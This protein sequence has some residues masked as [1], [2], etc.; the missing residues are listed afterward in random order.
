MGVAFAG[1]GSG[2]DDETAGT[3][4]VCVITAGGFNGLTTP[5]DEEGRCR[6]GDSGCSRRDTASVHEFNS[7]EIQSGKIINVQKFH[8]NESFR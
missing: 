1:T 3:G 7:D 6:S 8:T 5:I 4:T 2:S